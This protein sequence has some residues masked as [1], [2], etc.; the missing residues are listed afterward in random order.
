MWQ[1]MTIENALQHGWPTT[2]LARC[3]P[4]IE[5]NAEAVPDEDVNDEAPNVEEDTKN[6][7]N[8]EEPEGVADERGALPTI[9]QHTKNE[10]M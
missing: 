8:E 2:I 6:P 9:V 4:N 7:N 1:L 5:A 10:T 3:Y